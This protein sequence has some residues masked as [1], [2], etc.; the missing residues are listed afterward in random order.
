[1]QEGGDRLFGG[2][3]MC[4]RNGADRNRIGNCRGSRS[5][6]VSG[7]ARAADRKASPSSIVS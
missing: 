5:N 4:T 6:T 2:N 7:Q 1:M 3:A